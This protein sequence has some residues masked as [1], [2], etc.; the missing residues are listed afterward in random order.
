M[1]VL[2]ASSNPHKLEEIAAVFA[3]ERAAAA[4]ALDKLSCV[5]SASGHEALPGLELVTL[6]D[7][8]LSIDEPQEDQPTFEGNALLKA[9]YYANA[10]QLPTIADDSGLEVDAL[11]GQPGVRSAR[12][13]GVTQGGRA[14]IDPANNQLLRDNIKGTPTEKR[15]ARFVCAMAMAMPAPTHEA[16]NETSAD[17]STASTT[18]AS[19]AI[20]VR[21]EVPG[22]IIADDITPAGE[23]GFGYDPLFFLP[24]LNK[25]MAQLLPQEKN[26]LSHRGHAA[27]LLWEKLPDFLT[28]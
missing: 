14:V 12:Y 23:H 9:R 26:A 6:N 17:S 4:D 27:R 25:T 21:G 13:A 16:A 7:L 11:D 8:G 19:P 1:R 22:Q 2:V 24:Q 3:D 18:H 28:S 10:S 5:T 20:V 15:T